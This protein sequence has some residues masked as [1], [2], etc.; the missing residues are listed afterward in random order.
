M[1]RVLIVSR[2]FPPMAAVGV[3][4]VIKFCKFL[5][6]FGWEPVVLTVREKKTSTLDPALSDGLDPDLK[7]YR[8]FN[9]DPLWRWERWRSRNADHEQ[10]VTDKPRKPAPSTPAVAPGGYA[11]GRKQ[12]LLAAINTPDPD[13]FWVPAAVAEGMKIVRH[14]H[15]QAV[16]T[17]SPPPSTHLVGAWLSRLA[18]IPHI[19]DFRDLWTQGPRYHLIPRP[20]VCRQYE[21]QLEKWV[22]GGAGH[23]VAATESFVTQLRDKNRYLPADRLTA[24]TNGLDPDDF[25]HVDFPQQKNPKFTVLHLGSLYGLRDPGFFFEALTRFL[26]DR[27]G[28]SDQINVRMIGSTGEHKRR[29]EGTPLEGVVVFEGHKPQAEVLSELWAADLLLLILGFVTTESATIPAKLF[30]Y[31]A[32]GRPILALTPPGEAKTLIERHDLGGV[33]TE[34]DVEAT[35]RILDR[36]FEDWR[37]R[38]GPPSSSLNIPEVFTRRHQAEQLARI[39]DRTVD[40]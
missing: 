11:T 29:I 37:Q 6:E 35:C 4:R 13:V 24:I 14:E 28:A 12:S 27:P 34:P 25:A 19:V 40:R 18:R 1:K 10:P 16:L 23:I 9:L 22:L 38:T 36:Y 30:E 21:R 7:V 20:T 17:T 15:V 8:A 2:V 26:A 31:L 32:S 39:L 3:Y 33:V 5:P